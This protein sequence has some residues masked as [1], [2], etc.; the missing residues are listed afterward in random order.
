MKLEVGW[1]GTVVPPWRFLQDLGCILEY[2]LGQIGGKA[3]T[4]NYFCLRSRFLLLL[5]VL[6]GVVFLLDECCLPC[7]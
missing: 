6:E 4:A 7:C 5:L 1:F 3:I 2:R